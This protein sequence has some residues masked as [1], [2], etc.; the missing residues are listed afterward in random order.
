MRGDVNTYP[1]H[2]QWNNRVEGET[3]PSSSHP[4]REEAAS[5]GRQMAMVRKVEHIVREPDGTIAERTS[6]GHD[7]RNVAS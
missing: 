5:R 2:G 3:E 4:T 6:Y 1:E 7:P